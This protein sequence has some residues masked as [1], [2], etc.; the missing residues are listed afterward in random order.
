[1]TELSLSFDPKTLAVIEHKGYQL[2]NKL[3]AGAFGQV[4]KAY[5]KNT[6]QLAA[7]KVI[8][9]DLMSK[10]FREKYLPREIQAQIDSKHENLVQ[11]F[12][13]FRASKKLY[14]FMEFAA[15]GDISGYAHKHKGIQ[16]KMASRWFLQVS[17]GL[18]YLHLQMHTA[19]RDIKTANMLLDARY[20]AKL[21][22]FGFAKNCIDTATNQVLLSNTFCGTL[23]YECPE[24]LALKPYNAFKADIWSMGIT[25]FVMFHGIYP[26]NYKEGKKAMLRNIGDYPAFIRT[27]F[28]KQLP[29]EANKF[30]ENMLHPNED[31]RPSVTELINNAWLQ[32]NCA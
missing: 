21:S 7:V 5:N 12:D 11:V 16:E 26:F 29:A 4:F 15:N 1:M 28:C 3:G 18:A 17:K 24:I 32:R 27:R 9:L 22:Y 30:V 23:P 6:N 19:H 31:H 8:N 2:Q 10:K 14:I 25:F 13:I 20:I